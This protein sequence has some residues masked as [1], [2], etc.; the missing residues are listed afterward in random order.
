MIKGSRILNTRLNL[1]PDNKNGKMERVHVQRIPANAKIALIAD[2]D[3]DGANELIIGLTDRVVRSYRWS[4]NLDLGT[5]KLIGLNKWECANQ[6]GTLTI[7]D[8]SEGN[9]T[10]LVAQPGGTFMRIKCKPDK[11]QQYNEH[12]INN[13]EAAAS[14]I[15]YQTLG[16]SRM[17]NQNISTEIVG[18]LR[19]KCKNSTRLSSS[20]KN[21]SHSCFSNKLN[22]KFLV[23]DGTNENTL[24]RD[25]V[26]GNVTGGNMVFE[27]FDKKIDKQFHILY[28]YSK[29]NFIDSVETKEIFKQ[30]T[31]SKQIDKCLKTQENQ[32]KM[33][34]KAYALATLDGT[35]MLLKDEIIVW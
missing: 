10:L 15:D 21:T 24:D 22:N 30:E 7:H 27:D 8:D 13:C 26:D 28:E 32:C 31:S 12:L 17:R 2:M 16:I 35:I 14:C 3:K 6:I 4:S 33:E 9:S 19:S 5:G 23:L 11:C 1:T 18:N 34:S 20:N 29:D 25:T